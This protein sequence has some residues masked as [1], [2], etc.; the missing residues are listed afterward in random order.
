M[1][2]ITIFFLTLLLLYF[3]KDLNKLLRINSII[4]II[5]GYLVILVSII[6][7]GIIKKRISF[8]NI[9]ILSNTI[10]NKGINRG[11]ILILIGAIQLII[12]TI[13]RIYKQNINISVKSLFSLFS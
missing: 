11:L 10:S 9:S 7:N 5:S 2:Y 8:I 4:T 3:I 1:I 6:A 13:I 12:Y